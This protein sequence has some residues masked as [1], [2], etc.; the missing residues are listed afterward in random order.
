MVQIVFETKEVVIFNEKVN[1]D[2]IKQK[3]KLIDK[4]YLIN[5]DKPKIFR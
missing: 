4:L 1:R 2:I 3:I 5:Y